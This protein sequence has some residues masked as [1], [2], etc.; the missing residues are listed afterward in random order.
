MLTFPTRS[1]SANKER[2]VWLGAVPRLQFNPVSQ[3]A[4]FFPAVRTQYTELVAKRCFAYHQ[5][6]ILLDAFSC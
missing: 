2:V 1:I 3:E 5:R 6:R 4:H